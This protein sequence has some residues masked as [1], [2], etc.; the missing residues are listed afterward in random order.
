M[1]QLLKNYLNEKISN[2][3]LKYSFHKSGTLWEKKEVEER[4]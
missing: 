2:L 4:R 1:H 3:E